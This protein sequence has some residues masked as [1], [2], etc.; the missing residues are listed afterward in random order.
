MKNM[1]IG[2][3][4]IITFIVVAVLASISGILSI[5]IQINADTRYSSAIVEYGFAQGDIGKAMLV[6]TDNRRCA[7]DIV[8]SDEQEH[9]DKAKAEMAENAEKYA[10]YT[11]AVEANLVAPDAQA[12]YADI[13]KKM[14]VYAAKRDEVV[15]L[16][17]TTDPVQIKAASDKMFN[18]L[19]PLYD[20]LYATW[21]SLLDSKV[22]NGNLESAKITNQGTISLFISLAAIVVAFV[23][24]VVL[25]VTV[26]R[27]ITIPI[28]LCVKR[29]SQLAEGDLQSEVPH[30]DAKDETGE[31]ADS[32]KIIVDGF[33]TIIEDESYLLGEMANG[34]FQIRTRAEDKYV[35]DFEELLL[36][37][38]KINNNLSDTLRN[39][40]MAADQVS[41]G[42]DQ[43]AGAAQVLSQGAT[44]QAS[45]VEELNASVNEVSEQLQKSAENAKTATLNTVEAQETVQ[46][47][48]EQMKKMVVA[49]EDISVS[50]S[51]IQNIV[52]TIEDIASQTNLL[53]LNAAI[54][55][56]RA[57]EAGKGFAVVAE[58]V[59]SLAEESANATKDI[60]ELISNSIRTVNEGT[61]IAGET[62]ESLIK[63]V[64]STG[65]V[66]DLVD[67]IAR[68]TG[69]QSEYMYQISQAVEQISGV[70]QSNSATA[71]ESAAASEELS[72]QAQVMKEL[73]DKFKLKS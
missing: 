51:K 63:I 12:I 50:S 34:N 56:A 13:Q 70:V 62:A 39:I 24:A 18:E 33:R 48:N 36:S 57:G 55:A 10:T 23:I 30:I 53:S 58:E 8:L 1:R 19:D 65:K 60:T 44:E 68:A 71:E 20:D 67:E 21:A 45:S 37:I 29:I 22:V 42:S 9:M 49:M 72:G 52:K 25:G 59:R 69:E 3:K 14:E 4:L 16:G 6:V 66:G 47:G 31:L 38:R 46:I 64:E 15:E 41:S 28:N 7:R 35:G 40:N 11:K 32:T 27:G 5:A 54:E 73:V 17:Y 2:K 61:K 26:S 43:V